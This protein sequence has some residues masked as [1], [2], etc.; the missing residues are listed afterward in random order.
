ML[1]LK[2]ILFGYKEYFRDVYSRGNSKFVDD[3][4]PYIFRLD[5]EDNYYC[6]KNVHR[7]F[8]LFYV[9]MVSPWNNAAFIKNIIISVVGFE[10][11]DR[12]R[13]VQ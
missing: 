9:L 12:F 1:I 13:S 11:D 8:Y 10:S 6:N 5:D 7:P 2:Q 4:I 3:D